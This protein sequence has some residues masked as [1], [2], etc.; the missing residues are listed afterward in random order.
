M[1]R[2]LPLELKE[3][4]A[5][6]LTGSYQAFGSVLA[7]PATKM[8]FINTSDVDAYISKDNSTN[9][10]RIPSYG[11]L[12]LDESTLYF[13]GIDQEYYLP[14]GTQLYVKQVTAPGTT[15]TIICHVVTR[16]IA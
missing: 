16:I 12:T 2:V 10:A 9:M 15:G 8:N 13:R 6:T 7:N 5:S 11:T 3:F 14:K 1:P 4:T